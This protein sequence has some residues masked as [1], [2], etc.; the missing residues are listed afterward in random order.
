[1][2][3]EIDLGD[4]SCHR[5]GGGACFM[6]DYSGDVAEVADELVAD[7]LVSMVEEC[8]LSDKINAADIVAADLATADRKMGLMQ[9]DAAAWTERVVELAEASCRLVNRDDCCGGYRYKRGTTHK[10]YYRDW[11]RLPVALLNHFFGRRIIGLHT[12]S[13]AN[14]CRWMVFDFDA[15]EDATDANMKPALELAARIRAIGLTPYIFDSNGKGGLHVWVVF[16]RA[17]KTHR[18]HD[19]A[20][21]LADGMDCESFPKQPHV[22]PGRFGN[23]IRLPG[24]HHKRNHWSRLLT[25][26]GWAS[27]DETID[28]MLEMC[29]KRVV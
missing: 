23:W 24:K 13:L 17:R 4:V 20:R 15:H 7:D 27:A 22:E 16:P 14:T 29:G 3:I 5:L 25:P 2:I 11:Q 19:L 10:H 26:Q 6:V 1:M 18:V 8:D 21:S 9:P 28:A 12:T